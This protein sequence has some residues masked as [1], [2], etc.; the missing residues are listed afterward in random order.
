MSSKAIIFDFD[1]T[2][3]DSM[4]LMIE[5]YNL[6]AHTYGCKK[7]EPEDV[8]QLRSMHLRDILYLLKIPYLKLPFLLYS[9]L[10]FYKA[11]I[12]MV[13]IFD[14]VAEMLCSLKVLGYDLYIVST[15]NTDTIECFLK[16]HDLTFFKGVY[17]CGSNM[18]GKDTVIKE[19]MKKEGV[20]FA[21]AFYIG[22]ELRDIDAGH[23]VGMKV[24]AVSW[25]YNSRAML[26]SRKPDAIVDS[27]RELV[28]LMQQK[29][30]NT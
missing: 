7:V 28:A 16:E 24:I 3:A 13:K 22:D 10:S 23:Q 4:Q 12:S 15:N 18:F 19:I 14:G 27:P 30:K 20:D 8:A 6:A 21:N 9:T 11:K 1:G 25:G 26:A 17:S 29:N 2:L 5:S